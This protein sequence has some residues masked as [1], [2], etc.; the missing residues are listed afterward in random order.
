MNIGQDG[1]LRDNSPYVCIRKNLFYLGIIKLPSH[2]S[3]VLFGT[4]NLILNNNSYFDT[5]YNKP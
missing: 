5:K 4:T 3:L 1:L 2:S